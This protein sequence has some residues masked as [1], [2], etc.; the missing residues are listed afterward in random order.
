MK[1]TIKENTV[2]IVGIESPFF[3]PNI[4]NVLPRQ[5][6]TFDNI[7]GNQHTITSVKAGTIEPDGKFD[8]KLLAP[9]KKFE[10]T[11]NEKGTYEY[12]CAVHPPMRGK[13]II[14]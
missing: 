12:F 1:Q 8:S 4:I 2:D 5:T 13:I 6:I 3:S 10:I 9:G 7:D 14:S 11:L